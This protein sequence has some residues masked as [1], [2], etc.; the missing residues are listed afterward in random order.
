MK[1]LFKPVLKAVLAST[2]AI[3]S[4]TVPALA[5]DLKDMTANELSERLNGNLQR[6]TELKYR[7]DLVSRAVHAEDNNS[8]IY[9]KDTVYWIT[10]LSSF[11][12][13]S[14]TGAV[15]HEW[16]TDPHQ[17]TR[18]N[19]NKR[20]IFAKLSEL[21][22][23]L[24]QCAGRC[25]ENDIRQE[26]SWLN[27]RMKM[28]VLALKNEP[29][30]LSGDLRGEMLVQTDRYLKILKKAKFSTMD[31]KMWKAYLEITEKSLKTELSVGKTAAVIAKLEEK[32]ARARFKKFGALAGITAAGAGTAAYF[33]MKSSMTEEELN[34]IDSTFSAPNLQE[35]YDSKIE[36]ILNATTEVERLDI[37]NI[38][39]NALLTTR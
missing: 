17:L 35:K 28:T 37:E 15:Y 30:T 4:M 27:Q 23:K 18:M 3:T 33:W 29:V 5:A 26:M 21:K 10:A 25:H 38:E 31:E 22:H 2:L 13:I 16:D 7:A 24:K 6:M 39:I 8:E 1:A 12:T 14:V 11:L 32:A 19:E 34:W 9:T 36:F 20:E